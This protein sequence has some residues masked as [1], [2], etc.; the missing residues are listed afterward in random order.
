MA[1]AVED[2]QGKD[3]TSMIDTLK[4]IGDKLMPEDEIQTDSGANTEWRQEAADLEG[5]DVPDLDLTITVADIQEAALRIKPRRAPGLDGWKIGKLVTILKGAG[6]DPSRLDSWR[7]LTLLSE[8]GKMLERI[9]ISKIMKSIPND[10]L[11]SRKQFGFTQSRSTIGAI[12]N[13]LTHIEQDVRH[14]LVIFIDIKGAFN[15]MWWPDLIKYVHD[16]HKERT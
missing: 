4:A 6:K 3:T 14:H 16:A 1:M 12:K 2:P 15:N 7:P 11:I 8:L 10:Q 9:I 13:V 5:V